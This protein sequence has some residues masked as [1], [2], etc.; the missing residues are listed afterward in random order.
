MEISGAGSKLNLVQGNYIGTNAAGNVDLGNRLKGV[1]ISGASDNTIGGT[2][3]ARNVISGNGG[4]GVEISG[5]G[6][7]LNRVQCN[8]I[9]T[10]VT[11]TADLGNDGGGIFISSSGAFNVVGGTLTG[12]GNL[13]SGNAA[14]GV[15]ITLTDN[16]L[17]HGNYIGTNAAGTAALPNSGVGGLSLFTSKFTII[18]GSRQRSGQPHLR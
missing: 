4:N 17:V 14:S 5:A 18:G 9:G 8:Y 12:E 7:T 15:T 6:S 1:L 3:A 11:G 2:A 10:D 13:I 16:V